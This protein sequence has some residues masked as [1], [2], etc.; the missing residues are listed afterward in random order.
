MTYY[1]EHKEERK[2]YSRIHNAKPEVKAAQ[3]VRAA[4]L[5][6][7]VVKAAYSARPEV[8]AA[9]KAFQKRYRQTEKYQRYVARKGPELGA[10]YG[11]RNRCLN[12][13]GRNWLDYGGRG[14]TICPQW[15][16][17]FGQFL[18]DMGLRPPGRGVNG[19]S[20]YHLHRIDSDGN[21]EPGNVVWH[22]GRNDGKRTMAGKERQIAD[23]LAE[24]A[25][26]KIELSAR[27]LIPL[28]A[29]GRT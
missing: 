23:L 14:I 9:N 7:K 19:I 22:I 21:Y 1:A 18:A 24:N 26:L 12:S 28:S 3:K 5:E 20:L 29:V 4:T 11:M 16:T 2:T 8:K 13:S 6:A 25:A 17:D 27:H 15:L 10:F